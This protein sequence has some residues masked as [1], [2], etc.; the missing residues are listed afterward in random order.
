MGSLQLWPQHQCGHAE[1]EESK[2]KPAKA[3]LERM[4]CGTE[5]VRSERLC[6]QGRRSDEGA[7][8]DNQQG[9]KDRVLSLGHVHIACLRPSGPKR[10]R[11]FTGKPGS[12]D[13]N[14]QHDRLCTIPTNS[15]TQL[16][17]APDLDVP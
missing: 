9:G 5:L 4:Q 1:S 2:Q 16:T 17:T 13:L 14:D 11:I 15:A 3:D 12:N 8:H 7:R 6:K 10:K